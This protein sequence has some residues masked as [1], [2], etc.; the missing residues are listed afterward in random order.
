MTDTEQRSLDPNL[1]NDDPT[2]EVGWEAVWAFVKRTI[3]WLSRAT[4]DRR[5]SLG[6]LLL[7][8]FVAG[9]LRF[10]GL[11]WDEHQHLHPD[12]RFLTMVENS[13]TWPKS[14]K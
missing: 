10:T 11:D 4:S 1:Y 8:L 7:I 2:R 6:V 9:V 5:A 14:F 3:G 12:E 13:L